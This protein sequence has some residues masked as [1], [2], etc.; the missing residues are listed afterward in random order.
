MSNLSLQKLCEW[1]WPWPWTFKYSQGPL[2]E[3]W[4]PLPLSSRV[5]GRLSENL[6]HF[7]LRIWQLEAPVLF[8]F[9]GVATPQV[10]E[11]RTENWNGGNAF[12]VTL[13]TV[14]AEVMKPHNLGRFCSNTIP[15]KIGIAGL[16]RVDFECLF[17]QYSAKRM[18]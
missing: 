14:R 13:T 6:L 5:W 10:G 11:L 2:L 15:Y 7:S 18:W 3:H 8:I 12:P 9:L 16:W 1:V 4:K 17:M